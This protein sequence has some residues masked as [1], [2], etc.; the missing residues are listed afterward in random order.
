MA[1]APKASP[2]FG[3]IKGPKQRVKPTPGGKNRGLFTGK[4]AV[5]AK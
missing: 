5:K 4:A 1:K 3:P 2:K